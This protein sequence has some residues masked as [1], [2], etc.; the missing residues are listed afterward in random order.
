MLVS[1]K[2]EKAKKQ[3]HLNARRN[4]W[5]FQ[6]N[7]PQCQ[8]A[9]VTADWGRSWGQ[10]GSRAPHPHLPGSCPTLTRR[11]PG[12]GGWYLPHLFDNDK[13]VK[14]S[15]DND[16]E[17]ICDIVY[18]TPL[19]FRHTFWTAFVYWNS[20][21]DLGNLY[22]SIACAFVKTKPCSNCPLKRIFSTDVE[23]RDMLVN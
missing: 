4:I 22:Q 23:T 12:K 8:K 20:T 17:Y 2:S 1:F 15:L 11:S 18:E 14:G 16:V 3:D 9:E 21:S 13:E 7:D 19:Q 10:R 6:E 5:L